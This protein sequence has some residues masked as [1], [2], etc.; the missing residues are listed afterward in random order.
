M[1]ALQ[2]P[3]CASKVEQVRSPSSQKKLIIVTTEYII[4]PSSSCNDYADELA[5]I[6]N[7]GKASVNSCSILRTVYPSLPH[8]SEQFTVFIATLASQGRKWPEICFPINRCSKDDDI[9][10]YFLSNSPQGVEHPKS[11]KQISLLFS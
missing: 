4:M 2:D 3:G 6:M 10:I 7:P 11:K 8:P 5:C 1:W 9:K